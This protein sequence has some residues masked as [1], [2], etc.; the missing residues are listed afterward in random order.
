MCIQLN[1][2]SYNKIIKEKTETAL[3]VLCDDIY[4]YTI[5]SDRRPVSNRCP[6]GVN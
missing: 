5:D 2:K 6:L 1:K 3:S 4:I